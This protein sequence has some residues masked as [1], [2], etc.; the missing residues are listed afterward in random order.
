MLALL[1]LAAAG[2]GSVR[3]APELGATIESVIYHAEDETLTVVNRSTVEAEFTLEAKGQWQVEPAT[4]VLDPGEQADVA[5]TGAGEDGAAV[6]VRVASIADVPAGAQLGVL[7]LT[8]RVREVRPFDWWS[9]AEWVLAGLVLVVI[10][11]WTSWR[12]VRFRD[13]A[14]WMNRIR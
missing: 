12:V 6:Y 5:V 2:A 1:V 9:I 13:R 4:L 8:A 14:R 10:A 7:L 3:A 11:G